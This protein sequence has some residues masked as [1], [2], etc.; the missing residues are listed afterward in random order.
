VS[1]SAQG[2]K[3][4]QRDPA[5]L[6]IH[7]STSPWDWQLIDTSYQCDSMNFVMDADHGARYEAEIGRLGVLFTL[8]QAMGFAGGSGDRRMWNYHAPPEVSNPEKVISGARGLG[9]DVT[10]W[11]A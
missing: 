1:F 8:E 2:G 3:F 4:L 7:V 9:V 6:L 10:N 11:S 5:G